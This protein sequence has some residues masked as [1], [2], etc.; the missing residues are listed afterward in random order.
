MIRAPRRSALLALALV[1]LL[2]LVACGDSATVD[3][4]PAEGTA[5]DEGT[6]TTAA[7]GEGEEGEKGADLPDVCSLIPTD[8]VS[9][10]TGID[11]GEGVSEVGD[12]RSVCTFSAA[13][14]GG[15]G[16]TVGVESGDRYEEKLERSTE[17]FGTTQ[18]VE[19]LGDQ[20]AFAHTTEGD[21]ADGLSSVLVGRDEITI[22]VTIQGIAVEDDAR[23]ASV[24]LATAVLDGL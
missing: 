16:I 15:I 6:S 8:E 20:A 7:D 24:A 1:P 9:T 17:I 22:D 21:Y 5:A 18:P 11:L 3:Q 4:T 14:T 10:E 19:D 13:D 2:A 12:E 23:T